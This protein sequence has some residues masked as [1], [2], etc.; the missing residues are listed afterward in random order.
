MLGEDCGGDRQKLFAV[1]AGIGPQ[2]PRDR[3]RDRS[4]GRLA[5]GGLPEGRGLG[6]QKRN[7]NTEGA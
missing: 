6:S 2:A 7:S 4:D 3:R 1:P 5:G